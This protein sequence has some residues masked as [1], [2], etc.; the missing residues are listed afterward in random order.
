MNQLAEIVLSGFWVVVMVGRALCLTLIKFLSHRLLDRRAAFLKNAK[1]GSGGVC[2]T[3]NA[4]P[5]SSL[6]PV[7][8]ESLNHG[9]TVK[10]C[11]NVARCDYEE[12]GVG[13]L[14]H[15]SVSHPSREVKSALDRFKPSS[16]QCKK[17]VRFHE[18]NVHT[19]LPACDAWP[20]NSTGGVNFEALMS[21]CG[22]SKDVHDDEHDPSSSR[23]AHHRSPLV[24]HILRRIRQIE[25]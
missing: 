10:C 12:T 23:T 16:Q 5:G 24:R 18:G 17:C 21:T 7:S 19:A 20:V 14:K 11:H 9:H 4:D 6:F 25:V 1:R 13:G 2:V 3:W 22:Y 8:L 15:T